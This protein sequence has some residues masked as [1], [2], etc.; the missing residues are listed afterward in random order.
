MEDELNDIKNENN[1]LQG[2]I[3]KNN[4]EYDL[5]I[6]FNEHSLEFEITMLNRPFNDGYKELIEN[7]KKIN[8]DN[9]LIPPDFR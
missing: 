2:D 6:A 9:I 1:K 4:D 3:V 5:S 7:D 8:K